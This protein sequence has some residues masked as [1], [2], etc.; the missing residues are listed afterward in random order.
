LLAIAPVTAP[1]DGVVTELAVAAGQ[2][3]RMDEIL[4][5]IRPRE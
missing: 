5:V 1:T 2:Q 3:L 4:A